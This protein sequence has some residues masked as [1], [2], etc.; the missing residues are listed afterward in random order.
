MPRLG[1]SL[2]HRG[3]TIVEVLICLAIVGGALTLSYGLARRS[4]NQIEDAHERGQM[5]SL[6]RTQI[7]R[8][9][10]YAT[11]HP[12]MYTPGGP[13]SIV[14]AG[15]LG[16]IFCIDQDMV[17]RV[18]ADITTERDT[19]CATNTAGQFLPTTDPN[20][21]V[22][23]TNQADTVDQTFPLRSAVVYRPVART[24][25]GQPPVSEFYVLTGRFGAGGAGR[26]VGNVKGYSIVP[27]TYRQWP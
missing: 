9:K 18:E 3:D 8:L 11:T 10:Q 19:T 6:G 22:T 4:L 24:T 14:T 7:E 25:P 26:G 21:G 13:N 12:E 15:G 17:L 27:L 20:Y 23:D 5:L 1:R 2:G 16:R